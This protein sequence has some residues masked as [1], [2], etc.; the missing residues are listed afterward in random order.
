MQIIEELTNSLTIIPGIGKKT[1]Q[2]YAYDILS[3]D[4]E[5]RDDLIAKIQNL[6][7]IKKCKKCHGYSMNDICDY[8]QEKRNN[9]VLIVVAYP[10]D[11]NKIEKIMANEYYYFCLN[12]VIDPLNDINLESLNIDLLL[13][14]IQTDKIEELIFVLPTNHEGELTTSY[15]KQLLIQ[16]NIKIKVTKLAQGVPVGGDL[17]YLDELTLLRSIQK[18][19]EY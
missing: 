16:K 14:R 1:A 12:G 2:R 17:E 10:K 6:N 3:M 4:K 19:Q 9:K 11:I 5:E 7:K 15:I 8:C 13:N 18:R